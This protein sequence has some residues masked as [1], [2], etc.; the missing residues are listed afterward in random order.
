MAQIDENQEVIARI[1]MTIDNHD[2]AHQ[3]PDAEDD[4]IPDQDEQLDAEQ[5]HWSLGAPERI[6]TAKVLEQDIFQHQRNCFFRQ[7]D[8]RLKSFLQEH[9]SADCIG[10]DEPLKISIVRPI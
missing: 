5:C 6:T 1:R 4:K 8:S 9:I 2:K 7:F 3:F 10:P